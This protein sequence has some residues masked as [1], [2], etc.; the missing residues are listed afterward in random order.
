MLR[1]RSSSPRD[2]KR[3][4][5]RALSDKLDVAV[6]SIYWHVGNKDTLLDAL[7]DRISATIVTET[8]TGASPRARVISVA[9]SVQHTLEAHGQLVAIAHRRGRLAT[10]FAP[11]R[12]SLAVELSQ[13]GIR[14]DRLANAVNVVLQYVTSYATTMGVASRSPE[15]DLRRVPL[16]SGTPPVDRQAVRRLEGPTDPPRMFEIGLDVLVRGLIASA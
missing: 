8:P 16:W 1:S 9:R 4:R 13:A 3:C 12:R 15:Q 6:T 10:V 2:S 14:G 11:A 5:S 7:V